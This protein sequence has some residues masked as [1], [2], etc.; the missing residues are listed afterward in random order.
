VRFAAD[1]SGI[2]KV[3]TAGEVAINSRTRALELA[4]YDNAPARLLEVR[5]Q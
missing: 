1:G 4:N 3:A 2:G 5:R